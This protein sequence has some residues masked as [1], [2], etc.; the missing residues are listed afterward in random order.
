MPD[1]LLRYETLLDEARSSSKLGLEPK[2]AIGSVELMV[3]DHWTR[4]RVLTPWPSSFSRCGTAYRSFAQ[5]GLIGPG[6]V[7]TTLAQT[8]RL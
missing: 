6:L 3:I 7:R 2:L 5:S 1:H 4:L 8:C